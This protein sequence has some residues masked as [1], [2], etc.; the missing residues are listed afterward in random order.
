ME[1]NRHEEMILALLRRSLNGIKLPEQLFSS[2]SAEDWKKCHEMAVDQGVMAI[3]WDAV[4]ALPVGLQPPKPLKIKWALAVEDYAGTYRRY[5]STV[6]ELSRFYSE[7][8]IATVQL[9]GVGLSTYYPV[10]ERRQGGDIDIYTYSSDKSGMTDREAS[11]LADN[12]MRDAGIDVEMHS[13]KHSV[14][15]Y[16][17]IPVENHKYFSNVE[18]YAAAAEAEEILHE[19]FNPLPVKLMGG[20]EILV[21]SPEFNSVFV[22]LHALQHFT[23]GLCLHHLCDWAC[24]LKKVGQNLPLS[25]RDSH[26]TSAINA[27]TRIC[28]DYLGADVAVDDVSD[29]LVDIIMREI[30]NPKF[31]KGEIPR[32]PVG[33]LWYKTRR[34]VYSSKMKSRVWN[35]SFVK[36]V[37]QSVVS[38]IKEPK[39]IFARGE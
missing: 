17:G 8:G 27:L 16:K 29:E 18:H 7:H 14:F 28:R 3:A 4:T 5:C 30:L 34:F 33:I 10:P 12:L 11:D 20:E 32:N 9:K 31:R 37:W 6:G 2:C 19:Y 26:L 36:A 13:Y 38:H 24:V 15:H 21:P 23:S 1:F 22:S 35:T 39:T 25:V